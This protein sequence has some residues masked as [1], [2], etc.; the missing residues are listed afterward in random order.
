M[1]QAY[2]VARGH[3]DRSGHCRHFASRDHGLEARAWSSLPMSTYIIRRILY[4]IPILI[5][6]NF[7]TFALFFFVNTPDHMAQAHHKYMASHH[8][9]K[10]HK[11]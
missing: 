4:A 3:R 11:R 6:V 10:M 1:E 8:R 2:P 5:G 9:K 7:I